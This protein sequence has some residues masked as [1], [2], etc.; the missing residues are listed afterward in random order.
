MK[1]SNIEL[2][3]GA[4]VL[5]GI[6]AIV[7][8]AIQAGAGVS[9]G[10][11]T[12]EVNARFTNITGLKAGSQVFIAGV[13]VGRVDKIGLDSNYAAVVR[14]NVKRD[15]HLPS[16]TIASIKTSGL[17]GDKFI[18]LAPGA[19]SQNLPPGGT[20]TDTEP[21]LDLES[22][23]SRFAFGNVSAPSSPAPK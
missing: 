8:F 6:A 7:W 12:Y 15:I 20:I 23:I 4:F 3:V 18:A 21:A 22:L 11:S 1:Q 2:S 19:D 17:I 5:L 9:I 10:S 16:D 14:L 13:P